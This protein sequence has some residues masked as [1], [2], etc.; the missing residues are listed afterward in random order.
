MPEGSLPIRTCGTGPNRCT[1]CCKTHPIDPNDGFLKKPGIWCTLCKKGGGCT[2]YGQDSRP[3]ICTT[4]R[5]DW[6]KGE[7]DVEHRPDKTRVILEQQTDT[8]G[9]DV[10]V[11]WEVAEGALQ[12]PYAVAILDAAI[13]KKMPVLAIYCS[14][15]RVFYLPKPL[16]DAGLIKCDPIIELGIRVDIAISLQAPNGLVHV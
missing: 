14:G 12:R 15:S 8:L 9:G 11:M 10:L 13:A 3:P 4:F 16:A 2:V 7:G 5:C 1:A 6:L